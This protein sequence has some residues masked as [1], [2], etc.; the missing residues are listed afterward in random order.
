MEISAVPIQSGTAAP[1]KSILGL[2]ITQSLL[3]KTSVSVVL[4]IAGMYFLASGKKN[5]SVNSMLFGAALVFL[6]LLI[7]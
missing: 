6:A 2:D 5:R 4:G 7:F 1:G 3:L